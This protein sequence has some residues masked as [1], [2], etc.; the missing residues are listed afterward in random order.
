VFA[1]YI[2]KLLIKT[3]LLI[4]LGLTMAVW[5]GQSLRFTEF[6]T[7][8][9]L[10]GWEFLKI[11]SYLVPDLTLVTFPIGFALAVGVVYHR[12]RLSCQLIVAQSAGLSPT[13]LARPIF[14]LSAGIMT[15]MYSFN[16]YF[17]PLS[18][19]RF[20]DLEFQLLQ[21]VQILSA[22][23]GGNVA[24]RAGIAIF[25]RQKCTDG[26]LRGIVMHDRRN[27]SAPRS[28]YAD[29]GQLIQHDKLPRLVLEQG[30][31][32]DFDVA[33]QRITTIHFDKYEAD[34]SSASF[35][36]HQRTRKP[37]ERFLGELFS[38]PESKTDPVF[39]QK[40]QAEGHQRLTSPF[41]VLIFA[42]I[43]FF[44]VLKTQGQRYVSIRSFGR[45]VFFIIAIECLNLGLFNLSNTLPVLNFVN[46]GVVGSILV[47]LLV[48]FFDKKRARK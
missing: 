6:I 34:L 1:C 21:K 10:S 4:V 2:G 28:I 40:L 29:R 39:A 26:T 9:G 44:S 7:H 42:L 25:V 13:N 20:K 37:Y 24:D 36:T 48:Q 17:A 33:T 12:L 23:E 32:I 14:A 43:S 35:L 19:Q 5:A 15:I 45:T 46:Y 47:I 3:T 8:C 31:R 30:Q 16:L 38:P 41:L 18:M 27:A 22:A 11:A